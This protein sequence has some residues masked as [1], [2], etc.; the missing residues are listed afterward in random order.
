LESPAYPLEVI[1]L[2]EAILEDPTAIL[3]AQ[4]DERKRDLLARLKA[5]GMPYEDRIRQLEEVTHPQPDADFVEE[6]FRLFATSHPWVREEDVR[7]K[8][9]AREMF[10]DCRSFNDT[11]RRYAIARSEGLL[12]RYLSQVHNTLVRS[13]PIA[14]RTEALYDVIAFLRAT[15]QNVDTSLIEAWEKL[16]EPAAD[17]AVAVAAPRAFDLALQERLLTAR[18]RAELHALVRALAKGDFEEAARCVRADPDDPWDA[19]RFEREL[20]PFLAEYERVVFTPDAR[21]ARYTLLK[22]T[23][24]RSWD[25]FQVLVDPVGD[26]LWAIEAEVDLRQEREPEGPTLRMR[27]IGP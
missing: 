8:S 13:V 2:V 24:A 11:V 5:E 6:S 27:R 3:L 16:Q 23:G 26:D 15:L 21:Q 14:A 1:T 17:D 12:L 4:R 10:E 9:V 20:A 22:R 19:G 25:A 18:V 7:P